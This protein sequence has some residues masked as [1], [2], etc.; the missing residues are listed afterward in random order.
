MKVPVLTAKLNKP[1]LPDNM[2]FRTG[3]LKDSNRASVI[4]VSAQA[5]SGKSTLVSA[6]LS[7]QNTSY[8]WYALDEWDNDLQQFF[9]YLIAGV[10]ALDRKPSAQLEQMLEAFQSIGLEG[11]LKGLVQCLHTIDHPFIM[12][13]DDFELPMTEVTGFLGP[14]I[15]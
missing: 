5:G 9:A 11:F 7:E 4:L 15:Q 10:N 12:V 1:Q 2:I 6:W 3:L 8:F 14:H 13:F